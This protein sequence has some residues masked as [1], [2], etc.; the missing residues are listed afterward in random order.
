ME[1]I[2]RSVLELCHGEDTR[3]ELNWAVVGTFS[4]AVAQTNEGVDATLLILEVPMRNREESADHVHINEHAV[5]LSVGG[6]AVLTYLLG[7]V[8]VVPVGISVECVHLS[9]L[10]I[11]IID[12][13]EI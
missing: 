8:Q 11:H 5:V 6:D 12:D 13:V 10:F 1:G 3:S 7:L 4:F 2:N 9:T